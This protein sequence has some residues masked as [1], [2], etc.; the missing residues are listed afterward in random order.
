LFSDVVLAKALSFGYGSGWVL[1]VGD[2]TLGLSFVNGVRRSD[3]LVFFGL[4]LF[5]EGLVVRGSN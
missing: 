4:L 2:E 3:C 1:V 5:S